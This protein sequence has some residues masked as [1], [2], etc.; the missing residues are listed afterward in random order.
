MKIK[1]SF[2]IITIIALFLSSGCSYIKS[3]FPDKEKDYQY[4]TEIPPLIL[5]QDLQ[6]SQIPGLTASTPI[7]S[8]DLD[9]PTEESE[10]TALTTIQPTA[11]A[12]S[13]KNESESI[14]N[15]IAVE[16]IK[17]NDGEYRLRINAP[18]SKAWRIV[19]KSLSRKSIEVT[20]R[21]QEKKLFTI[22]YESEEQPQQD[23][24]YWSDLTFM[25]SG[26]H[27][28]EKTYVIKLDENNDTTDIIIVDEEH[29][30]LSDDDSIKLLTLLENTIK[31]DLATK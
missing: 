24:S 27:S 23:D 16:R 15:L 14:D 20:D 6:K 3:L 11:N 28:N 30:P 2:S 7:L 25:L 26:V 10:S 22:K 17:I 21:N 19:N 13:S 18:Y 9:L 1:F 8:T 5:P 31:Q 4:T 29:K 12:D